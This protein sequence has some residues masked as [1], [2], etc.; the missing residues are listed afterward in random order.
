MDEEEE[1]DGGESRGPCFPHAWKDSGKRLEVTIHV[2]HAGLQMGMANYR[3]AILERRSSLVSQRRPPRPHHAN[4][5][6]SF[7]EPTGEAAYCFFPA[8]YFS[9]IPF[10]K[11]RKTSLFHPLLR[12]KHLSPSLDWDGNEMSVWFN[13]TKSTGSVIPC[14]HLTTCSEFRQNIVKTQNA[15]TGY[16]RCAS[17]AC[18]FT[19]V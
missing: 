6:W 19:C 11:K 8:S 13:G 5:P 9:S 18:L 7:P 10:F 12:Q 4:S 1:A 2:L 3:L 16:F 15:P 14:A 17:N